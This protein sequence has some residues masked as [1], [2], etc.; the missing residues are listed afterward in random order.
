MDA[1]GLPH[2]LFSHSTGAIGDP[3]PIEYI[4]KCVDDAFGVGRSAR[5][6]KIARFG[7]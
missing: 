6:M 5:K 7:S 4:P 1:P 3:W 2:N